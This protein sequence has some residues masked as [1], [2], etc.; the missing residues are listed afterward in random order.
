LSLE[1]VLLPL[2]SMFEP[3]ALNTT[4]KRRFNECGT[5]PRPRRNAPNNK[6]KA[7][8]TEKLHGETV[9]DL[10]PVTTYE[11]DVVAMKTLSRTRDAG[12]ATCRKK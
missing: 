12:F 1:T 9:Y 2:M 5:N 3:F 8:S 7:Q 11:C 6:R 10:S 4:E